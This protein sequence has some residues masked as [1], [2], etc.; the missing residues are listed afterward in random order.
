MK[1]RLLIIQDTNNWAF[2]SASQGLAA[3]LKPTWDVTV[4]HKVK[5]GKLLLN[6]SYTCVYS[7]TWH[8]ARKVLDVFKKWQPHATLKVGVSGYKKLNTP[9][10]RNVMKHEVVDGVNTWCYIM[11]DRIRESHKNVWH[12]RHGV[13]LFT[14]T[15]RGK[16]GGE[17]R[18]G[19]VG[20]ARHSKKMVGVLPRLKYRVFTHGRHLDEIHGRNI[21]KS[22]LGIVEYR[23]LGQVYKNF[24]VLVIPS[25]GET[26]PLPALEAAASAL[27]IISTPVGLVPELIDDDFIVP[28]L[29]NED[30]VAHRMNELLDYFEQDENERVRVGLENRIRVENKFDWRK[31]RERWMDF[32]VS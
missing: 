3:A 9:T 4:T 24:N 7:W 21:I 32:L 19:W 23:E 17:F 14:F 15:P 13:D 12:T 2:N 31:V 25:K 20:N 6:N 10:F 28:E 27:P 26:G 16:W 22:D 18:A 29:G 30:R 1:K 5:A 11:Y 8:W